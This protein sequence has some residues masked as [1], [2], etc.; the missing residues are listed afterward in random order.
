MTLTEA[1][2]I[3]KHPKFGDPEHIA[4]VER[5]E[6]Q[7][8]IERISKWLLGKYHPCFA[9]G[10]SYEGCDCCK[11]GKVVITQQMIDGWQN[12]EMLKQVADDV[13]ALA[14]TRE[15]ARGYKKR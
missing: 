3:L 14:G 5:M 13:Q 15:A 8:E 10:I 12:L 2:E 6:Q 4:A 11:E 7:P 1:Q 9:C